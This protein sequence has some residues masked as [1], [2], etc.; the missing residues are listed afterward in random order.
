MLRHDP[1]IVG[2]YYHIYNRGIDKRTIFKL[3]NDYKRF[4]A[5]LFI[6]NSE[7]SFHLD[8]FLNKQKQAYDKIFIID[9]GKVLVSIGAWSLMPNHFHIL[10]KQESEG[11]IT[12]FMKKVGTGYS[13]HFNIKYNRQGA[14]F[15]GPFKSKLIGYDDRYM[16]H[17][18]GYIHINS[19]DI[20]FPKWRENIK[21]QLV[22]G[23]KNFLISYKYSSYVDYIGEK[24][25]ENVILNRSAFP[26]YFERKKNFQ[27]FIES[28]FNFE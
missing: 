17:L 16:K 11:G 23:M 2:E 8:D 6:A 9:R 25:Q 12:S 4:I 15:G 14:L 27:D 13:M 19:L 20:R 21:R 22:S 26:D 5:L 10:L 18:F 1:F 3:P 7:K 24:R 28:Y